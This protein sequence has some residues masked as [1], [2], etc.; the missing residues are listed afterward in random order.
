MWLVFSWQEAAGT[1][2][3]DAALIAWACNG[4]VPTGADAVYVLNGTAS[5]EPDTSGNAYDAALTGTGEGSAPDACPNLRGLML[6]GVG[7]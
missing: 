2:T 1:A 5:P 7:R 3:T 6:M 4:T